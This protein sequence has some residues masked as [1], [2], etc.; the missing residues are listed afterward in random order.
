MKTKFNINRGGRVWK[1]EING[2]SLCIKRYLAP[3]LT[4]AIKEF[5]YHIFIC[6]KLA[7]LFFF[8]HCAGGEHM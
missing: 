2:V 8:L 7:E 3:T 5:F 6:K 4:Y 1:H